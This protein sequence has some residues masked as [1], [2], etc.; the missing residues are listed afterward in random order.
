[1]LTYY[2]L[3]TCLIAPGLYLAILLAKFQSSL[4]VIRRE[5]IGDLPLAAKQITIVQPILG[6]DP[7]LID[8]LR[9]TLRNTPSA[10]QFLW[11]VDG[12][13][14]PGRDAVEP[15]CRE[16]AGRIQIVWCDPRGRESKPQ[17]L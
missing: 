16:H 3:L 4:R 1:M 9:Q 8:M 5:A 6:G 2:L 15:L 7:R 11:L 17:G 12:D 14:R 10:T 13:D